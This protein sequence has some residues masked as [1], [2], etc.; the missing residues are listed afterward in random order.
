MAK[1]PLYAV[2]HQAKRSWAQCSPLTSAWLDAPEIAKMQ[3]NLRVAMISIVVLMPGIVDAD[4][5]KPNEAQWL[6]LGSVAGIAYY[7]VEPDGFHVIATLALDGEVGIPL[8]VESVLN[9]GQSLKIS[10]PGVMGVRPVTIT[11]ERRGE[12][13]VVRSDRQ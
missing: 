10:T 12:K 7:T 13:L 11:L 2:E 3:I 1:P 9:V 4:E 6:D 5:P 8:R